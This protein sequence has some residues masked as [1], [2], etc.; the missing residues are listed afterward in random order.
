MNDFTVIAPPNPA[1]LA[2]WGNI[3]AAPP[4]VAE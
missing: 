4:E 3:E 2:D 1:V